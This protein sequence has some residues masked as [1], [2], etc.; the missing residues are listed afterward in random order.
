MSEPK[1]AADEIVEK[2]KLHAN[3]FVGGRLHKSSATH[4]AILEV[5]SN[6]DLLIKFSTYWSITNGEWHRDELSHLNLLLT[7]LQSR[8]K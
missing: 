7:E 4:C 3:G 1:T 6:I 5:Q 8:I 2:Y